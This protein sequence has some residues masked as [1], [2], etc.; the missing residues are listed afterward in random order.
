VAE[1][2]SWWLQTSTQRRRERQQTLYVY[3][4]ERWACRTGKEKEEEKGKEKEEEKPWG[5]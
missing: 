5:K 2:L 4:G 1:S 3:G